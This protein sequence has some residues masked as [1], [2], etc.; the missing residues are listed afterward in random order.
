[1]YYNRLI[2]KYLD[3]WRLEKGRKPILLRGTRQIGKS[4]SVRK[5]GKNFDHFIEINFEENLEALAIFEGNL[6]IVKIANRIEIIFNTLIKDGKTL[7]FLDEIQLCPQALMSMRYFYEK[8]PHLHIIAAG[9]LLEFG[10]EELPS[11][12]VGRIRSLFMYPFSFDEFLMAL[13][14]NRLLSIKQKS[15]DVNP[16]DEIFH[17]RLNEY[18]S[19]FM[20]IG[21][22]P[23]AIKKYVESRRMILVQEVLGDLNVSF[24]TDFVK[25]KKRMPSYRILEVFRG[26]VN[27]VGG[28]FVS[29]KI[30]DLNNLQVKDCIELLI[31]AGLVI[32]VTHTSA[33][34]IPLGAEQ[35]LKVKKMH[36]IDT[37]LYQNVL[38]LALDDL[39]LDINNI[40]NKGSL[41]DLF[42]GLEYIKYQA[43]N[44]PPALYY[45]HREVASSNAEVDYVIQ[46]EN[47]IWPIEVKSSRKGS[48]QSLRV[49]I[50]EKKIPYGY[51][52]SLENFSH[53]EDIKVMPL[54]A[55]SNLFV[56]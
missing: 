16:L 51:R 13:G 30:K 47:K 2:D 19:V 53:Y 33:N 1:M 56:R 7:L 27:Q 55:V 4:T 25:Y 24:Q 21:G 43:P 40:I 44:L 14:E 54:Y 6:D 11:F 49:Y 35:N 20:I 39:L 45:W 52:F 15:S 32:P 9:S 22:F 10:L 48:M 50:N 29:S 46:Q 18:L 23:D 8:R 37:G 12:G 36:V 5:L 28:K 17:A 41:A 31:K 38:G 3:K 42:W 26:V 34:G